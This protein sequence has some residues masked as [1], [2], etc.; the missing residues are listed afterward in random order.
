MT[1]KIGDRY[2]FEQDSYYRIWEICNNQGFAVLIQTDAP[3]Y[4]IGHKTKAALL[5]YNCTYLGNFAKSDNFTNLY[6]ILNENS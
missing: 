6:S 4:Y 3:N 2:K 1:P 5:T